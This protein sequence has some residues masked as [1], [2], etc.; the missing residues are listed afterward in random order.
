MLDT[1]WNWLVVVNTERHLRTRVQRIMERI[2][3]GEGIT[4]NILFL[5]PRLWGF[6]YPATMAMREEGIPMEGVCVAAGVPSLDGW[7]WPMTL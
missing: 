2:A 1:M 7:M 6:Q 4:L 3:P 5:N